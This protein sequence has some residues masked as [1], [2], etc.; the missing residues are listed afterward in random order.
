M[1]ERYILKNIY[2]YCTGNDRFTFCEANK[3]CLNVSLGEVG[4]VGEK[5]NVENVEV[6]REIQ[7][8]KMKE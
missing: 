3:A 6:E 7:R 2:I 8:M 5:N 1:A 4:E